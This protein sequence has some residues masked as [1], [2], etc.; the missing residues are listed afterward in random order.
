MSDS[1]ASLGEFEVRAERK[2]PPAQWDWVVGAAESGRTYRKNLEQFRDFQLRPKVLAGIEAPRLSTDFL[3][4]NVESPILAAPMGHLTQ[5]HQEGELAVMKACRSTGTHCV[6]SMHTR[7][8]LELLADDAGAAGWSYQAYLYSEP[9]IVAS[10]IERAVRLGA[11]SVVLTVDSCHRSPSYQRQTAPWD[12]RKY[13]IRDEAELPES[14]N[15]RLWTWNMVDELV[16]KIP[17][18]V[19]VKGIQH[20]DDALRAKQARCSAVWISN[21]GGR[22]NETDQ[23]LLLELIKTK[24]AVGGGFPIVID[25]GFRSGSDVAKALLLGATHVAIGRPL[26][27][28]MVE[29]GS[30]GVESVIKIVNRELASMLGALGVGDIQEVANH[31]DQISFLNS[32]RTAA[33]E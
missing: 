21:H 10:Q 28:G 30:T 29:N 13:G 4:R 27:Y 16:R 9:E 23:S 2:I 22:V 17:I 19:V 20:A 18:P 3:G 7:R 5:F 31:S 24:E 14:R 25:G 33:D 1:P 15:D 26:I 32:H 8:S 6:V 11:S 12:A